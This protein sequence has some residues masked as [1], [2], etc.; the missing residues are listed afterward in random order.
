[1]ATTTT[2]NTALQYW[3]RQKCELTGSFPSITSSHWFLSSSDSDCS[4]IGWDLKKRTNTKINSTVTCFPSWG[5]HSVSD[6][7][8]YPFYRCRKRQKIALNVFS[9]IFQ[10]HKTWEAFNCHTETILNT[11]FI[12]NFVAF[13]ICYYQVAWRSTFVWLEIV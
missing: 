4:V 2:K 1:M 10:Q 6:I 8:N 13:T 3:K 12:K 5:F 7:I 9:S 11:S